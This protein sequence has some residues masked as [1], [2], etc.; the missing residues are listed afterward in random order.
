M[1]EFPYYRIPEPPQRV[2][3]TTVLLRLVDALGFR[4]RWASERLRAEDADFRPAP[5]CMSLFELLK[6]ILGLVRHVS[7]AL[8]AEA[9]DAPEESGIEALRAA[10]LEVIVSMRERLAKMSDDELGAVVLGRRGGQ[11]FPIWNVINGPIADAFTHVGQV[12]GWRRAAGNP[13]PGANVFKG[14]PPG[15]EP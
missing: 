1:N 2:S 8:G 14:E 9:R 15:Q 5:D 6:H 3:G 10:T 13:W 11:T 4:Y 12:N 7:G